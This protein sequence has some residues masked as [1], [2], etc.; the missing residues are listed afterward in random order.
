MGNETLKA[1]AQTATCGQGHYWFWAGDPL[2]AIPEGYP[3]ACGL[4]LWHTEICKE[5]GS[6]VSKPIP[7]N[8]DTAHT[9]ALM[10]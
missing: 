3:C 2:M 1:E 4:M 6:I 9:C 8:A 5:C 7:R 10:G